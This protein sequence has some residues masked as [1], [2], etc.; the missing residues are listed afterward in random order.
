M[1]GKWKNNKLPGENIES[2]VEK[3][4]KARD[5]IL[6]DKI[7]KQRIRKDHKRGG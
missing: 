7:E 5:I 2:N 6:E 1:E 4:R 3:S